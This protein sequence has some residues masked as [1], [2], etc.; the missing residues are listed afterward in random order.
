MPKAKFANLFSLFPHH[1]Y[2]YLEK[3][4]FNRC[5]FK[6]NYDRNDREYLCIYK[7]S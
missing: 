6:D 2:L 1:S 4:F 5:S 3:N 7:N